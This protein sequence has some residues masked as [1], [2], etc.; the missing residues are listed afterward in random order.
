MKILT[1]KEQYVQSDGKVH[2]EY[3]LSSPV[4]REILE[5]FS[6]GKW[7][8]SGRQYLSPAFTI[9]N[10]DG[11]EIQG[12][13]HSPLITLICTPDLRAGVEDYL[14]EFLLFIPD[15]LHQESLSIRLMKF[16]R[17]RFCMKR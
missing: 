7:I 5:L 12:I 3:R 16:M 8:S 4:T 13:L 15:S 2:I 9:A 17:R 14:S 11:V 1:S 6:Q 10:H